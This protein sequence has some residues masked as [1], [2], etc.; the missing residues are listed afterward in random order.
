V[1][2]A[3]KFSIREI[4]AS[5]QYFDHTGCS[6]GLVR[7]ASTHDR[8]VA[9]LNRR[10]LT[11]RVEQRGVQMVALSE[12]AHL[13]F[14]PSREPRIGDGAPK[15]FGCQ[16]VARNWAPIGHGLRRG[17]MNG[18]VSVERMLFS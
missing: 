7:D 2:N 16:W 3:I 10:A 4:E 8:A 12:R 17:A 9:T 11:R 6:L 5:D 15:A 18:L 14:Q 13:R 1:I